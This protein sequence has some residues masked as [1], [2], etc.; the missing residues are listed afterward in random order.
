MASPIE[1]NRLK[2][3][4]TTGRSGSWNMTLV[5]LIIFTLIHPIFTHGQH[6]RLDLTLHFTE[7]PQPVVFAQKNQPL[8]LNC[9]ATTAHGPVKVSWR[10]V[11]FDTNESEDI[12]LSDTRRVT[13]PDGSLFIK[14]FLLHRKSKKGA[15]STNLQENRRSDEGRYFCIIRNP[16]GALISPSIRV[17]GISKRMNLLS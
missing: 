9:S 11:S 3:N 13:R 7:L 5:S 8:T 15:N 2:Q 10:K 4:R 12:S 17:I 14:K 16:A 1:W 6:N